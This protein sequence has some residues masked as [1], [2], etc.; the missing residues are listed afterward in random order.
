MLIHLL[1]CRH[2][3]WYRPSQT[4]MVET[5]CP[6]LWNSS[7]IGFIDYRI[8]ETKQRLTTISDLVDPWEMNM[9]AFPFSF[10]PFFFNRDSVT[11]DCWKLKGLK[12]VLNL[13]ASNNLWRMASCYVMANRNYVDAHS[14]QWLHC[15]PLPCSSHNTVVCHHSESVHRL[16]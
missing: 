15:L 6:C 5:F 16:V 14:W 7:Q 4:I 12:W 2:H 9:V 8:P 11:Q 10:F 1:A 13:W 3:Y